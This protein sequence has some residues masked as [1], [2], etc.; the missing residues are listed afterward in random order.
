MSAQTTE[1]G[2]AAV[3][4]GERARLRAFCSGDVATLDR[5]LSDELTYTHSNGMIEGKAPFLERLAAGRVRFANGEVS[6]ASVRLLGDTAIYNGRFGLT[7]ISGEREVHL[8]SRQLSVWQRHA[9][10]QWRQI[11]TAS[12]RIPPEPS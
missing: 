12:S 10:G 8:D 5:L 1:A 6:E 7:V 9:D 11:A 3:L 4:E 2:I